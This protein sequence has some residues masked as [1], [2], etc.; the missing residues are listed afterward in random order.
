LKHRGTE[1]TEFTKAGLA[2][3]WGQNNRGLSF[4][5]KKIDDKNMGQMEVIIFLSSIF[6]SDCF[7]KNLDA[8]GP[9]LNQERIFGDFS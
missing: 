9:V 3:R 8:I 4:A 7:F 2:E 6:L 5:D 1:G